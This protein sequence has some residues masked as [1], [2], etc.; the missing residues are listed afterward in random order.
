MANRANHIVLLGCAMMCAAA[1]SCLD[2]SPVRAADDQTTSGYPVASDARLAGD[3]KQTRFVLDLAFGARGDNVVFRALRWVTN[4]FVWA[5]GAITPRVVPGAL[6]TGCAVLWVFA[7]RVVLVQVAA[8]MAM[9]R[10]MG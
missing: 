10:M 7:A 9:R 8:A 3:A 4:P 2:A 6:V 5:V 1:L